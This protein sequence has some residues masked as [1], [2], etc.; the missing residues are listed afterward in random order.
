MPIELTRDRIM[1]LI[2]LECQRQ[3]EKW[4]RQTHPNG[5]WLLILTEELGEA[6]EALLKKDCFWR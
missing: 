6:S 2:V 5:F 3:T 1:Q 4:G